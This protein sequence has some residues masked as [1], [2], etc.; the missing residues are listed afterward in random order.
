MKKILKIV[1]NVIIIF[2]IVFIIWLNIDLNK[3]KIV[4]QEFDINIEKNDENFRVVQNEKELL[5]TLENDNI[6]IIEIANDMDLG[7]NTLESLGVNSS[8]VTKHNEALTHPL[9][10]KT[11]V[12]KLNIENKDRLYI[13][14]NN[15]SKI[16]HSNI[17]I[18]KSENIKFENIY[19][20][21][22]W[23]WDEE[24]KAEYDRNDWDYFSIIGCKNIIIKNCEFGKAYDEI[25]SINNSMNIIVE[26]CKLN[27][28]DINNDEFFN[29]QFIEL[30]NN[31]EKYEMYNY[32]R[33]SCNLSINTI[34]KLSSYQFKLFLFG[35]KDYE[36]YN[37]NIIIHDCI[38]SNVKT[39]I[40]MARNSSVYLYNIWV[41]SSNIDSQKILD[42]EEKNMIKEKYPKLVM[43]DT[44]GII[45]IQRS[46]ILA[47]N[48]IFDDVDY[49]YTM[50]R[51]VSLK[52]LGKI[53]VKNEKKEILDLKNKLENLAGIIEKE[54]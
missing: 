18:S 23:E 16:L 40:P 33:E 50:S 19:F 36:N 41:D 43:L 20:D 13:Y 22:L 3:N 5:E 17:V 12:S 47:E 7:F 52:N 35:T 11:G 44:Y 34:K 14:S 45:A 29:N 8:L 46:Y 26:Y 21:E 39:R 15:G 31:K 30:E 6:Q 24:T 4:F 54:N 37:K 53:V 38:F 2:L 27:K 42:D 25:F 49:K 32:L 1:L 10:I 28:I 9:L 51:G 48:C